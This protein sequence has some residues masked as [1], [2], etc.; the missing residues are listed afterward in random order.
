MSETPVI[1]ANI[2]DGKR[3]RL[4][5][6]ADELRQIK[7]ECGRGFF[8]LYINFERD[9]E[10]D[11]VAAI[12]RLALI[13]GGEDPKEAMDVVQYYATPPRPMKDA[14]MLAFKAL[15][16]AW[17]GADQSGKG[18]KQLSAKEMDAFFIEVEAALLKG[19]LD[20]SALKGKSFAEIQDLFAAL[21]KDAEKPAAP[22]AETFN[23]IKKSAQR[24]ARKK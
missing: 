22:D 20:V 2:G 11:E 9:A 24:K 4:F 7:R 16:A 23:A 13:G 3:R 12:L 5:L 1:H 17:A 8:T 15:N 19:G 21:N 14:Y 10:P 18:G 6:G